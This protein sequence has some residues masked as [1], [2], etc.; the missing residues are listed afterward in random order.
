VFTPTRVD[1]ILPSVVVAITRHDMIYERLEPFAK[2]AAIVG[3]GVLTL[4]S[5]KTWDA[6]SKSYLRSVFLIPW[7]NLTSVAVV[8]AAIEENSLFGRL[9]SLR[10]ICWLGSLSYGL[11]VFH[12][13]YADWFTT[14]VA[15]RLAAY[16]PFPCALLTSAALAFCLTLLLAVISTS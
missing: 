3:I 10:W 13:T 7:V 15:P 5:V 6:F 2:Y 8:V 4:L 14:T 16:M 1:T 11:Y 9:C 12:L